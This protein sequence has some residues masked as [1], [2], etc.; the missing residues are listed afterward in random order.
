LL[1]FDVVCNQ[2]ISL[3][4]L[5]LDI[6][7]QACSCRLANPFFF[8]LPLPVIHLTFA[9]PKLTAESLYLSGLPDTMEER[10][11]NSNQ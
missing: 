9:D 10:G 6:S 5:E 1:N 3:L 2:K 11:A 7:N 8:F 4:E